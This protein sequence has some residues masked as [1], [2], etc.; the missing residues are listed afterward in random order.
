M[1]LRWPKQVLGN[2][3]Y[4]AT[5]IILVCALMFGLGYFAALR[6]SVA[7]REML[8]FDWYE[9]KSLHQVEEA[10]RK[11]GFYFRTKQ[12]EGE[13]GEEV[14]Q[15]VA[16]HDN[17]RPGLLIRTGLVVVVSSKDSSDMVD[18]VEFFYFYVGL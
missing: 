9:G 10:F 4:V 1:T 8:T 16:R 12:I 11:K 14:V 15:L 2:P 3:K 17:Y 7:G 18:K 13:Y 6:I 5:L